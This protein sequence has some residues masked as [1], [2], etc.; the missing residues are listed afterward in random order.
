MVLRR[1]SGP[2]RDEIIGGWKKL[3]EF[4]NSSQNIIRKFNSSV[5]HTW[6]KWNEHRDLVGNP[7]RKKETIKM[8]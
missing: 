7:E 3:H 2:K 8:T 4:H 6:E 1:I 5:V